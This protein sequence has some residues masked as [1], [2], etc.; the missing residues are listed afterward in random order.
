[1]YNLEN[2]ED[3]EAFT[4]EATNAILLECYACSV[5]GGLI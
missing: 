1:M 5:Y 2:D 4:T 3:M